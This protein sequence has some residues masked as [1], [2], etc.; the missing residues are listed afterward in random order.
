VNETTTV[1]A[2]V[3]YD[4]GCGSEDTVL[5]TI[6]DCS[7]IEEDKLDGIENVVYS[8]GEL[9]LIF[10][11]NVP[12]EM[13]YE[14]MDISGKLV[15][16]GVSYDTKIAIEKQLQTGIYI[17]KLNQGNNYKTFKLKIP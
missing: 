3:W 11:N 2:T 4:T 7:G 10:S 17:L 12:V 14:M 16:Y 6:K 13:T 9:I 5:V 8:E 15:Q 1:L